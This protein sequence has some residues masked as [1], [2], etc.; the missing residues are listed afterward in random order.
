MFLLFSF[1]HREIAHVATCG[2]GLSQ[3][4]VSSVIVRDR[5]NEH[6]MKTKS[7]KM[8]LKAA[9]IF[10]GEQL[11]KWIAVCLL[12]RPPAIKETLFIPVIYNWALMIEHWMRPPVGSEMEIWEDTDAVREIYGCHLKLIDPFRL[13]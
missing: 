2:S 9:N 3:W 10:K 8:I 6:N 1:L 11:I 13:R 12:L 4:F 7:V 5:K